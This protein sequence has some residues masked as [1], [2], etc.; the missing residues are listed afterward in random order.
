MVTKLLL[1][2]CVAMVTCAAGQTK[3]CNNVLVDSC[4]K[5]QQKSPDVY[6]GNLDA[7]ASEKACKIFSGKE[8]CTATFCCERVDA[9]PDACPAKH[10]CNKECS[11]D[12][13]DGL[14]D[15]AAGTPVLLS[16]PS[17]LPFFFFSYF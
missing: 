11:L 17:F 5:L 15:N 14:I 3:F 9:D 13:T 4:S 16:F 10:C 12:T 8:K 2:T 6:T 7:N 1:A